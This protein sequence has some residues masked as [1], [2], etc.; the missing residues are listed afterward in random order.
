[1]KQCLMEHVEPNRLRQVAGLKHVL[2]SDSQYGSKK[3]A[4]CAVSPTLS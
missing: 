3:V 4:G 2:L 1:M